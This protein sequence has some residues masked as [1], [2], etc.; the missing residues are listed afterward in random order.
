MPH[1]LKVIDLARQAESGVNIDWHLRD[2]VARTV[3][4]LGHQFNAPD[5]VAAYIHGM[6]SAIEAAG[7]M[8]GAYAQALGRAAGTKRGQVHFHAYSVATGD[9]RG[10]CAGRTSTKRRVLASTIAR[11]S[12]RPQ[13]RC[14]CR[15]AD[16]SGPVGEWTCHSDA[17]ACTC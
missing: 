12:S 11:K 10:R 7:R 5:L 14:C 6:Q 8:R 15:S 16:A 13:A 9:F 17:S 3:D 1:V 2:A 4:E